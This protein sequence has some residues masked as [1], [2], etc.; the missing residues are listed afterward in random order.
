VSRWVD[1]AR[2]VADGNQQRGFEIRVGI[3]T[4]VGTRNDGGATY[5]VVTIDGRDMRCL[6]SYASP[7]AGDVVVWLQTNSQ[8]ICLGDRL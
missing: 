7:T 4:A 6:A 2:A 5:T 1:V 8:A 3:V